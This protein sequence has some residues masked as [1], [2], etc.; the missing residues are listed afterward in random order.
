MSTVVYKTG[1]RVVPA[2]GIHIPVR[3]LKQ[4]SGHIQSGY[5]FRGNNY[6]LTV[7]ISFVWRLLLKDWLPRQFYFFNQKKSSV[8]DGFLTPGCHFRYSS[9]AECYS[10]RVW[11]F[12]QDALTF[13]AD[14]LFV[15]IFEVWQKNDLFRYCNRSWHYSLR[16]KVHVAALV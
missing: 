3:I 13:K 12:L 5:R 15:Y 14:V 6:V 10:G 9:I 7:L 16:F 1:N 4:I 8:R 11:L 2:W